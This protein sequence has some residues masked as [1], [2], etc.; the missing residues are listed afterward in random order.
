MHLGGSTPSSRGDYHPVNDERMTTVAMLLSD[1]NLFKE[2]IM[3]IV[4]ETIERHMQQ[5]PKKEKTLSIGQVCAMLEVD[6]STLWHWDK[7]GYLPKFYI[8]GKPR[9][10]ESE[11]LEILEG[12]NLLKRKQQHT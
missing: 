11:V 6:R 8:G 3:S 2:F 1:T 4:D 10:K 7:E 9:Y 5:K 12:R